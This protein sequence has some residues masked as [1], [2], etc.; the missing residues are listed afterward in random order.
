MGDTY[1]TLAELKARFGITDTN[2][3]TALTNALAAASRG[4]EKY[5]RR[6][7][8]DAG[9]ASSRVYNPTASNLA[10]VDDFHTTTGLIVETDTDDDG[11]FDTTWVN[12]EYQLEPL[13]G[14]RDGLSGWPYWK[15]RAVDT[16]RFPNL[17]RAS[18]RVT[19]RWGWAAVP[20]PIK[21]SCL[22][23]AEET[24]KLKDAPFGVAGMG[25]FGVVRIQDNRR[26]VTMLAPY[27]RTATRVA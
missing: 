3:D 14:V 10:L 24:F 21:E 26:V 25:E 18:L 2:D 13:N 6:Q 12:S 27:R 8:N 1:A 19:A 11:L 5:C 20:A 7:F 4:I 16:V 23:L 17:S 15:I 22:A 9:A